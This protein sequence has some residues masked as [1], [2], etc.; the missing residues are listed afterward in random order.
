M[1]LPYEEQ[2]DKH[3][4]MGVKGGSGFLLVSSGHMV[5]HQDPLLLALKINPLAHVTIRK[6]C[7]EL[8]SSLTL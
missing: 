6:V 2:A 8:S 1:H 4:T 7:L 3:K 5:S